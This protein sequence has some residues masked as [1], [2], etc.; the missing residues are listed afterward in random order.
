[1]RAEFASDGRV[2]ALD[3]GDVRIGVA[4][5]DRSRTIAQPLT[6]YRRVGYGPDSAFFVRLA[7]EQEAALLVLGLPL[8]MDGSAGFQ[9]QKV[10]A[11]GEVLQK[12][13]LA[14]TY[15]D[16][17]MTTQS[18]ERALLEGDM[19][20]ADRRQ[21]V[22]KIAAAVILQQWLETQAVG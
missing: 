2:L 7:A 19:R 15:Q 21:T 1:M 12:A 14:V 6:V 8:N 13:G 5:S 9:A 11:F 20:R 4:V 3:V 16:E 10:R 22:D 18:A 17:R